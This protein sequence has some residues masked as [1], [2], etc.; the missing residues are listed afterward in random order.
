MWCRGRGRGRGRGRVCGRGRGFASWSCDL[1]LWGAKSSFD[2][3][4]T[5]H[6]RKHAIAMNKWT[7]KEDKVCVQHGGGSLSYFA[8]FQQRSQSDGRKGK[9]KAPPYKQNTCEESR[10]QSFL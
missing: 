2:Y 5:Q 3:I 1:L 7:T 6:S 4:H 9:T 8:P 10:K